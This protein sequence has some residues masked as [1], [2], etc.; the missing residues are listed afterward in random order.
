MWTWLAWFITF[1]FVNIA[2]VFFRAK[3][4]DDALK[5]LGAMFGISNIELIEIQKIK[6]L[7]PSIGMDSYILPMIILGFVITLI[8]KNSSNYLNTFYATRRNLFF[9]T[10]I[11]IFAILNLSKVSEFLYFNF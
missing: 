8:F 10:F 4:W 6:H 2:W 5:V 9:I 3:E 1:N 11:F 7:F